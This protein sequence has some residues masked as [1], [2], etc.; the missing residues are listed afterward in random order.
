MKRTPHLLQFELLLKKGESKLRSVLVTDDGLQ[1][2]LAFASREEAL[3]WGVVHYPQASVTE[4]VFDKENKTQYEL[5]TSGLA[6]L[7]L[8]LFL[9]APT[10]V[11]T[12]DELRA[13]SGASETPCTLLGETKPKQ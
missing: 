2:T 3:R 12:F 10:R 11:I 4:T 1:A 5:R 8:V 9:L 7:P 13:S 6:G